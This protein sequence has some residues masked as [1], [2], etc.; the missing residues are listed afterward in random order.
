MDDRM[1]SASKQ[2]DKAANPDANFSF[3]RK[4]LKQRDMLASQATKQSDIQA[5]GEME[6]EKFDEGDRNDELR[7]K[8]RHDQLC[9]EI[10]LLYD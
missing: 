4:S 5:S 9:K 10:D 2:S 1:H 8:V 3:E 7:L 6:E